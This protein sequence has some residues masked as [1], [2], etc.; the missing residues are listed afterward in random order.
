[1]KAAL[2]F[3]SLLLMSWSCNKPQPSE[4]KSSSTQ[5]NLF[6]SL[7]NQTINET[8]VTP[9][10]LWKFGRIGEFD[11]SPD[12][13]WVVYSVTRYSIAANKGFTDLFVTNI[14]G[15]ESKH[16]TTF[17]G[18]EM[19]PRWR[20]DGKKIGFIATESGSPQMWEINPDGSDAKQISNIADGINSF[21]YS[22][23]GD[24]IYYTKDVQIK[25]TLQEM[26]PD[27]PKANVYIANELMYRHWD[28]WEDGA[29]SHIFIADRV[30]DSLTNMVD[31]MKG[32]PYDSPLSPYFEANEI[33][34]STDGSMIA[35][36]CKKLSGKE[37]A[38]STNS[39]IYLYNLQTKT[40]VNLTEGM[41]GYDKY[42]VF[43]HNGKYLAWMSMATPGYE[44]DKMRLFVYNFNTKEK[45]EL[46]IQFD[47]NATEYQWSS[48][49][50]QI[51]FISDIRGTKQIYVVN[52][53]NSFIKPLTSG[54]HDITAFKLVANTL[55]AAKMSHQMATELYK[56]KTENGALQA[57]TQVNKN[58]Y[59]K[60]AM[61]ESRE[62][63][64]KTVD[65]KQMLVW[66][67]Y[68]PH[69]DSTK[70]YPAILYCQGGPQSMV[71]QFFSYRWNFQIMAAND[72]IIVAP[73]R[74]GLPG[75]GQEW[76]AQISG[77]YGG[78]NMQDYLSAIDDAKKLPYVDAE[79]L[80]CVGASYGGFSVYWLAGHHQK[81][82]KAFIAHCG[83]FNL[84]SQYAETE[85]VFFTNHDL[86]GPFWD[87]NNKIAQKSYANSP[88][89]FVQNWDTPIM[90][91]SGENDFRIP[92]TESLQAFNTAQLLNIP[93]KLLIFPEES[94]FVLKPQNSILWQREFFAWLDQWL[95]PKTVQ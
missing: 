14:N 84:E 64:V 66:L 30:G 49:D 69:F 86:G 68:P 57:L 56:V 92:Y 61:G 12:G 62:H 88:H 15:G 6:D 7:A 31:I 36:T 13:Q 48:D 11:I 65:G 59:D 21:E 87:K 24:K 78:L 35:Y 91:I 52:L 17:V 60:V 74:R 23:K 76:N 25:P 3:C 75:F 2:F 73:N 37:Y 67:I 93:S 20:P 77:D 22:P 45:K 26:Y 89:R 53:E 85:E 4:E 33:S 39:D 34:W 32:E 40:T 82:F 18:S 63:W 80:G 19:N 10:L 38:I 58:I 51:Y 90:I 44:S 1:M 28:H 43:S 42:P 54:M 46:T 16:L 27:L 5:V 83:M 71:S 95:K 70:K 9:E 47:Q 72:Y 29:Y 79:H 55:V 81:R 50:K 41:P 8:K 94:H